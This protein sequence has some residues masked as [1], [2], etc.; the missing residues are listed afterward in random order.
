M[1]GQELSVNFQLLGLFTTSIILMSCIVILF[2]TVTRSSTKWHASPIV[3]AL[4]LFH[5]WGNLEFNTLADNIRNKDFRD[6]IDNLRRNAIQIHPLRTLAGPAG[7]IILS[8]AIWEVAVFFASPFL[9]PSTHP[10]R[11]NVV[12]WFAFLA[13]MG[14]AAVSVDP[15]IVMPNEN[16]GVQLSYKPE[17]RENMEAITIIAISFSFILLAFNC[18]VAMIVDFWLYDGSLFNFNH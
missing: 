3:I 17:K 14:L 16:K 8:L 15:M 5:S 11:R 4:L 6:L 10:K 7:Y 18:V 1:A 2:K 13:L 9:L 12:E